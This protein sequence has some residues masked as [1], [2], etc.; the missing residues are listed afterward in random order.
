MLIYRFNLELD[1][2]ANK[3]F[4]DINTLFFPEYELTSKK[5]GKGV[6]H[7]L[8][9]RKLG[10]ENWLSCGYAVSLN[11]ADQLKKLSHFF[12]DTSS[13]MFDEFQSETNHYCPN[14]VEKFISLHKTVARGQGKMTRYVPVY[15]C[16][17]PVTILNPYYVEMDISSRLNEN[18]KFLR[19]N[20]YVL[21]QGYNADAAN[22]QKESGFN[23]AFAKNAYTAYAS[24]GVYLNDSKSFIE[25]PIGKS[26]YLT[27]IKY[28]NTEY[29]VRSYDSLGIIYCDKTPDTTYQFRIAV[30]T[31]DH[32]VNYVMLRN[33]DLFLSNMR[34]F[35]N[36]GCF[37]F[38]DLQ[39]K[40][41]VL[42]MLSY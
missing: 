6:Y 4:K 19:G 39:C 42:K 7:E 33:N 17:N 22:A 40:E 5:M 41:A 35:F 31:D 30:T 34:Y 11:N 20:G 23:A 12:S 9:T 10:E 38:K 25:K 36:M 27:T 21:E 16:A 8:F 1:D 37:R 13:M 18:V 3:F 24:E 14:E 28:K 15:M 26:R 32:Q 29:G 2:C